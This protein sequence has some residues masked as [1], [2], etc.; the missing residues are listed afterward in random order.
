MTSTEPSDTP[1][2]PALPPLPPKWTGLF[3]KRPVVVEAVQLTRENV[4][5]VMRW[6]APAVKVGQAVDVTIDIDKGLTVSTLEGDMRAD[7]GW[8][9]I[10]GVA[11]EFYPCEPAI[12]EATYT[13]ATAEPQPAPELP[14]VLGNPQ[15]A[16]AGWLTVV[17]EPDDSSVGT[18]YERSDMIDAYH[19]GWDEARELIARFG[20]DENGKWHAL[21][22]QPAPELAALQAAYAGLRK[23]AQDGNLEARDM[24]AAIAEAGLSS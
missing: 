24:L 19:A 11:G 3:R 6:V 2:R 8:W 20:R 1:E 12:F 13:P 7:Y 9:V 23:L 5:D 18:G 15:D 22:P 4:V 14:K 10:K 16:A 21:E 17:Y